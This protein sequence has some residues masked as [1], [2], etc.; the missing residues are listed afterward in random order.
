MVLGGM[1]LIQICA[2]YFTFMAKG[3]L[4]Y[5]F[6]LIHQSELS[7]NMLQV[8]CS[9]IRNFSDALLYAIPYSLKVKNPLKNLDIKLHHQMRLLWLLLRRI[10][11]SFSTGIYLCLNQYFVLYLCTDI[12]FLRRTPTMIYV[13]ESHVEK[14]G[15]VQDVTYEILNVLEFNR[16]TMYTRFA[17]N[18]SS[19]A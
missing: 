6:I 16:Y 15:K 4:L 5:L 8:V 18:T 13:R 19:N 9:V 2:R 3:L 14:M 1:N 10:S 7:V 12:N 11:V 17:K